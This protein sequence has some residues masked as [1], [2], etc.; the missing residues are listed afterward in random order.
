MTMKKL[1][2]ALLL[3]APLAPALAAQDF[4]ADVHGFVGAAFVKLS[5][6]FKSEPKGVDTG[7]RVT[8]TSRHGFFGSMEYTYADV[9]ERVSGVKVG[10]KLDELRAGGGYLSAVAPNLRIGGFVNYINQDVEVRAGG[11]GASSNGDGFNV[12]LLAQFDASPSFQ[13]YGRIGYINLQADGDADSDGVDLNM[14]VSY[15]LA[16][17]L[18]TFLEYRYTYLQ[19]SG[20]NLDYVSLRGGIKLSY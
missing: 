17:G 12:G 2:T 18:A 1:L 16:E 4:S 5:D 9:D 13:T 20:S 15:E 7:V 19:D 8:I 3:A 11:L 10:Y 14:G 6:D